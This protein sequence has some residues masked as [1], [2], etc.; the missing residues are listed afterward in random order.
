MKTFKIC[1]KKISENKELQVR[2]FVFTLFFLLALFIIFKNL[3]FQNCHIEEYTMI[4][5]SI[6]PT[7]ECPLGCLVVNALDNNHSAKYV[8]KDETTLLETKFNISVGER[9]RMRW[10]WIDDLQDERVRGIEKVDSNVGRGF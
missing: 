7:T 1:L 2:T 9:F 4:N 3:D 5:E 8:F 6:T 10:C